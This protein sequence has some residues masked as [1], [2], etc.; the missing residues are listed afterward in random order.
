MEDEVDGVGLCIPSRRNVV[1]VPAALAVV[2]PA[3][4]EYA[5]ELQGT[6]LMN[7]RSLH[8][9]GRLQDHLGGIDRSRRGG[10][11]V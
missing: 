2:H 4:C 7:R 9:H 1:S 5:V 6:L 10:R 8:Y 11:A 3:A